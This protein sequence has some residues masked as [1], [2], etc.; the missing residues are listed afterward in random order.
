LISLGKLNQ[1]P[2]L[3]DLQISLNTLSNGCVWFID[4]VHFLNYLELH[5]VCMAIILSF[6]MS[7][8]QT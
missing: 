7:A 1:F 5:Y 3:F 2:H 8:W 6:I 4:L